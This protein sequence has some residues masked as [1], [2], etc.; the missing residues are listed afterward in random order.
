MG[1]LRITLCHD[2]LAG[3]W[4]GRL[5]A[6]CAGW[7]EVVQAPEKSPA[8]RDAVIASDMVVGWPEPATLREG[9]VRFYQCGST[10]YEAYLGHGLEAKPGF[11]MANAAGTMSRSVAEHGVALMLANI[12]NL[13]GHAQDQRERRFE[14]RLPYREVGGA[15]AC[16]VGLGG[17]GTEL[18]KICRGLGME[19]VGV[20]REASRPH[21]LVSRIFPPEHLAEAVRGADHIF[22][23][24]PLTA[25]TRGCFNAAVFATMK[26]GAGLYALARGAHFVEADLLAAL[27]SGQ[28]GCAGLDVFP[29]EPLRA[30][31][32][33]WTE[34]NVLITPHCSGR[35]EHEFRRM[36]EL[37]LDNIIR[38]REGRPLRNVVLRGPH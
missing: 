13:W 1:L 10:G 6:A 23:A 16:L 27:R 35:S 37:V 15:T 34:P 26:P 22:V 24:M 8:A 19:L 25:A 28:V 9:R 11:V 30:D 38:Y 29:E 32:P 20:R 12:R 7:A 2:G 5:R 3:E 14:K 17:I 33:F 21:P 31:S 18:A 4:A 36:G